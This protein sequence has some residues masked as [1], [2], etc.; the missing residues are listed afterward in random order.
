MHNQ[1]VAELRLNHQK[2]GIA[3]QLPEIHVTPG[4]TRFVR[5]LTRDPWM[6]CSFFTHLVAV[7]VFQAQGISHQQRRIHAKIAVRNQQTAIG[8]IRASRPAP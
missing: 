5:V 7:D 4:G 6:G 2:F 1:S 8:V 3:E